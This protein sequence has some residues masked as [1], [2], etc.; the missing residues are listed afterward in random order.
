MDSSLVGPSTPRA[1][2]RPGWASLENGMGLADFRRMARRPARFEVRL[3]V[4]SSVLVAVAC[5]GLSWQLARGA[6]ADLRAHLGQRATTVVTAL[7]SEASVAMQRGDL[8]AL[9]QAP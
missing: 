8:Q 5:A 1:P 6:L 9:D 4:T 2:H 7:A 3:G